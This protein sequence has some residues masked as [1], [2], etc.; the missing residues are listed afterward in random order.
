[1]NTAVATSKNIYFDVVPELN[2]ELPGEL[3]FSS[4]NGCEIL[5][6]EILNYEQ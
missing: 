5:P 2:T 3:Y 4:I 6:T 1:M